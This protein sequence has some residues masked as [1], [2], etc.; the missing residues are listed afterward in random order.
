MDLD[1]VAP[2]LRGPMRKASA[3][4]IEHRVVRGLI[5]TA[6]AV[7]P[8]AK[9]DGV[10]LDRRSATGQGVRVHRPVVVQSPG[11][12]LWIHGGGYVL[13]RAILNDRLCGEI[14]RELGITVVAAE[15]RKAP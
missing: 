15:Y 9:V 10:T 5:S 7:M 6:L 2:E 8:A 12:L 11:A 4:G 14:A 1:R 3:P 13:G